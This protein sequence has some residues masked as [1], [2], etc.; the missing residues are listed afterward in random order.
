MRKLSKARKSPRRRTRRHG[1][2][3]VRMS[4]SV[5]ECVRLNMARFPEVNWSAV[6]D[7]AFQIECERR[8]AC[9]SVP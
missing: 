5:R 1:I 3:N 8:A 9:R 4:I 6:A 7:A 2:D